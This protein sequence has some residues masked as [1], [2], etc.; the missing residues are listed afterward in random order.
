MVTGGC[1]CGYVK[2]EY[3]GELGPAAYCH[4]SD[5]RRV[6]G[7]GFN[8]GVRLELADFRITQGSPKGFTKYADSGNELTR[9]FC[10]E[11]G[12]P[13][14]TSAPRHANRIYLK[15]GTLD[16][17]SLVH[18]VSQSWV[19]SEVTWAHINPA[20]PRHEKGNT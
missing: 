16:D 4:C 9:H 17:A 15:A 1:L 8:I 19:Q 10:P 14:Y 20:L 2:Y 5:C 6:T 3:S 18:P 11:C 7:N 13:L 12:S